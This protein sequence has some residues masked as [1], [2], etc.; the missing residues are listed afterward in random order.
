M[1]RDR[2][3]ERERANLEFS[4]FA[5]VPP[6]LPP[7]SEPPR[8]EDEQVG[9]GGSRVCGVAVKEL[10]LSYHITDIYI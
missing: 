1:Y 6:P 7:P 5:E 10:K 9:R 3:R 4:N 2:E 8:P